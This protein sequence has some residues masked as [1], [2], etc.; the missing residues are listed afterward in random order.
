M[1]NTQYL[2]EDPEEL[3]PSALPDYSTLDFVSNGSHIYGEIMW[4]S[5]EV[6]GPKTRAV[7]VLSCSTAFRELPAMMIFLT[8]CAAAAVLCWFHIIGEPGEVRENI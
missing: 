5:S 4:P 2:F 1:I 6:T 3:N 7:L 8:P